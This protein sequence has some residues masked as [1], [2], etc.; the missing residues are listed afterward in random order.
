MKLKN[1]L[2]LSVLLAGAWLTGKAQYNGDPTL[3]GYQYNAMYNIYDT[4]MYQISVTGTDSKLLWQDPFAYQGG[5][6]T[7]REMTAGWIR[8]GKLC[9]Y[10][11][12][13]PL[14]L[15]SYFKY[16]ERDLL[17]GVI[18]KEVNVDNSEGWDNYF[19]NAAY[20]PANDRI[21]GY[22]FNSTRTAFAFKSAP[23]SNPNQAIIIKEVGNTYP[24]SICYNE[25][26][27]SFIGVLNTRTSETS[28]T[29]TLVSIDVNTGQTKEIFTI[30][31]GYASDYK[32]TG[33]LLWIPARQ[34]YLWNFY[35]SG[36]ESDVCSVLLELDA[37]KNKAT[38]LRKFEG[39]MNYM[40]FVSEDNE[41]KAV[42]D[43][44]QPVSGVK[45]QVNGTT[46]DITFTLPSNLVSGTAISGN[47]GYT[48]YVDNV[49]KTTGS[50]APGSV[51]NYNPTLTNG[52]HFIRVV[53]SV[54]G[55]TGIGEIY[56]VFVGTGIP[57]IPEN[58][59]LTESEL[60][61]EPVIQGV[62]G[63]TLTDVKYIVY[64]NDKKVAETSD[65]RLSMNGIILPEGTLT[66]Y[67]AKIQAVSDGNTSKDGF[68]NRVVTGKPWT[69]PFTI[70]PTEAQYELLIQEDVDND[71]T[72][73]TLDIDS[74]TGDYVLTSGFNQ[75]DASD[76]WIYL[77]KFTAEANKVYSFSF[78]VFLAD[79]SL[80]GGNVEVW[81]GD[82]P[83]KAAM[84]KVIIPSIRL[85]KNNTSGKY[86]GE[87]VANGDLAGKDLY[88]GIGVTSD[89][90]VLSPLRMYELRVSESA[91]ASFNG[92]EAV[93]NVSVTRDMNDSKV[94]R[95]NFTMPSKTLA[96]ANI[97][98]DGTISVKVGITNGAST[99]VTGKPGETVSA[100]ITT[101]SGNHLISLTPSY[102]G[103]TGLSKNCVSSL[104]LNLPGKVT[105][106]RASYDRFNT[107]L[108]LDWDAPTT[109]ID[110]NPMGDEHLSYKVWTKNPETGDFEFAVDVEYP[111]Q[112][113]TM[114]E[115]NQYKNLYNLEVAVT[116]SNSMGESQD[117]AVIFCQ[118]GDP[119][120]LPIDDDFNG[121][122]F[123]YSPVTIFVGDK[124]KQSVIQWGDPKK[125]YWTLTDDMMDIEGDVL[126]GV[127]SE[128]GAFSRIDL[129]KVTATGSSKLTLSLNIWTGENA[130]KTTIRGTYPSSDYFTWNGI[131]YYPAIET[132]IATIP[133][134]NG[135]Q[136][137][138]VNLPQEFL[139]QPWMN[140]IIESQYPSL[141]SRFILSGYSLTS[142]NSVTGLTETLYGTIIG[143]EG[144]I[145]I[146]GYDRETANVYRLD[147]TL[148][149]SEN[150]V[151]GGCD[152]SVSK[153]VYIVK[154]ANRSAK[155]VVK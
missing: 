112:F 40:Y 144:M 153:G 68:S 22:G 33:A 146:T 90:N 38:E 83:S 138:N 43:A 24:G 94:A 74:A 95:V 134:G 20:C 107:S 148:V 118:V 80:P 62:A 5:S 142:V 17:T 111:L 8:N 39:D 84:K 50:G 72:K 120:E 31:S 44:P 52:T 152:I 143:A 124:Y 53:P 101:E 11:A 36:A 109:D 66:C 136:L 70:A 25:E 65:T 141:A 86:S 14:P 77:P 37:A 127:P 106:L 88:I 54:S 93:D 63:N 49:S 16:V 155:V 1:F 139:N 132:D 140:I 18:T 67:Q 42:A 154:V 75:Y 47:V 78:N 58:I 69:L 59:V 104:N 113:A 12:Y 102:N 51:A 3:L 128:V 57:M 130:A 133:N 91:T 147:G 71:N 100:D 61:W 126:C 82:A 4:G 21:Y 87:F 119:Y 123:K 115:M 28:Y 55:K 122:E 45:T 76:D 7:G 10:V 79:T 46:V 64:I 114:M 19:L 151:G 89:K 137:I 92:P 13:Y 125:G 30:K 108:R 131:R 129:P 73:W 97:P 23:A 121:D 116:S 6:G 81:I 149:K 9:G 2:S 98:A 41:P 34:T 85:T 32:C 99:T 48:V 27:G 26:T 117:P 145:K 110:G 60:T 35:N 150:I 15:Q 105:N 29:N 135:Y 56:S 96:G 103:I